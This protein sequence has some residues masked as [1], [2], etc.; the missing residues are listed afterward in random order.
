MK[1]NYTKPALRV[2]EF[3]SE[4]GFAASA[5]SNVT[6]PGTFGINVESS[7]VNFMNIKSDNTFD[8]NEQYD[9]DN[10]WSW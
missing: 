5:P 9:V 10:T 2:V 6:D 8:Q 4:L 1:K 7:I 3:R